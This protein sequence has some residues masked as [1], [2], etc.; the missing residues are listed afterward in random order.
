MPSSFKLLRLVCAYMV[1]LARLSAARWFAAALRIAVIVVAMLAVALIVVAF[2]S[3]GAAV[4]LATF[5]PLHVACFVV[6][7][8]HLFVLAMLWLMLRK[9]SRAE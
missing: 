7:A 3:V 8:F 4:W 6:A 2:A 5:V 1:E 9:N